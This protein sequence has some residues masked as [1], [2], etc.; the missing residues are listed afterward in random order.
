MVNVGIIGAS[1][2]TGAELIRILSNHPNVALSYLT[3]HKYANQKVASLYPHLGVCGDLSFV[4]YDAKEATKVDIVFVALPHGESMR[5]VPDLFGAGC[6]IIDLSGDFRLRDEVLYRKWYG[7]EHTSPA[8]LKE[9]VYGLPEIYRDEIRQSDFVTNPGC[10]P[11]GAILA[12]AP[13]LKK[14]LICDE[15]LVI[16]SCSGLSGAGRSLSLAT[17]FSECNESVE[18]YA[19]AV[20]KHTPEMEQTMSAVSENEIL[21]TFV[22][23]LVPVTR[24]IHTTACC[25]LKNDLETSELIELYQSFYQNEPFTKIL[26]E[27]NYPKTKHVLGSN[28]CFIGVKMDDRTRRAIVVTAIDNLVKGAAG[29]AVQN[30]NIMCGFEEDEGLKSVG[31]AP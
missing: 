22:P 24:G 25:S 31:L 4:R 3:A 11:T 1:G 26:E 12:V 6:R 19:V 21:V 9:A 7:L 14:G 23:H 29:Q 5:V 15:P 17:H 8:L 18:A 27:G 10:Y 20:H 16:G 28:Y 2:Y 30:M 13:M